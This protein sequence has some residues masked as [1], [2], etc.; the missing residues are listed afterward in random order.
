MKFC[1]HIE[2]RQTL[3]LELVLKWLKRVEMECTAKTLLDHSN[4][5][6]VSYIM[7]EIELAKSLKQT[8]KSWNF[9]HPTEVI[10]IQTTRTSNKPYPVS[11]A[12]LNR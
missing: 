1:S 6:E 2:L 4:Q 11:W 3:E 8:I 5:E 12:I 9:Y 10:T 7:T